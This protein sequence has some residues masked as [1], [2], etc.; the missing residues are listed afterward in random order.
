M[1]LG[2]SMAE[3][4]A[5]VIRPKGAAIAAA[6]GSLERFTLVMPLTS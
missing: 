1:N 3:E 6:L 2:S 4:G 5:G